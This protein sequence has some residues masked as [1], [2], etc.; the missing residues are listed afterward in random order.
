MW[1]YWSVVRLPEFTILIQ[2]KLFV[3]AYAEYYQTVFILVSLVHFRGHYVKY[4]V[5]F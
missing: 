2:V 1:L 5:V 3:T 4:P